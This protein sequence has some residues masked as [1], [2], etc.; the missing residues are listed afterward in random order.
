MDA[1]KV[2]VKQLE[3]LQERLEDLSAGQKDQFFEAAAKD[4]AARFLVVV[5][6]ATPKDT[7]T[8]RRGWTSGKDISEQAAASSIPVKRFGRSY[9]ITVEN[10]V[11]Y[12]EYV[13]YGHRTRGGGYVDPQYFVKRSQEAF[14]PNIPRFLEKKL[15]QFLKEAFDG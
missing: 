11:E 5:K 6:R 15:D 12:A 8:L 2:D 7:G 13:E 1:M 3:A 14:E 9:S 4:T 10:N